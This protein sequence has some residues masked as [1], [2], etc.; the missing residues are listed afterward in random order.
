[1]HGRWKGKLSYQRFATLAE[2]VRF[3]PAGV[4]DAFIEAA[5]TQLETAEI[6]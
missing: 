4:H 5:E 3:V 6:R 2:A 1:V